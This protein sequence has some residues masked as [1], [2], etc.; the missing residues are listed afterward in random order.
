MFK[1]V[2]RENDVFIKESIKSVH[3]ELN[4][5]SYSLSDVIDL[6]DDIDPIIEQRLNQTIQKLSCLF[7]LPVVEA[8]EI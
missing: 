4:D 6:L 1:G 7:A 8:V 3:E 5:I 2:K